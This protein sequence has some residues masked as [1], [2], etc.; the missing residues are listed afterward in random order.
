MDKLDD[1][2]KLGCHAILFVLHFVKSKKEAPLNINQLR[3]MV[4]KVLSTE[5]LVVD[6]N[7]WNSSLDILKAKGLIGSGKE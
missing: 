3:A 7:T 1:N 2:P 6:D 4:E 5:G